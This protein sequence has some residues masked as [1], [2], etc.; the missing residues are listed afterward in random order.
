[1]TDGDL[2]EVASRPSTP[3]DRLSI[4]SEVDSI[5]SGSPGKMRDD[6]SPFTP[7]NKQSSDTIPTPSRTSGK[8]SSNSS[9]MPVIIDL[10]EFHVMIWIA[11]R[12]GKMSPPKMDVSVQDPAISI[13]E[14]IK[15][16][17]DRECV[18]G[19][20]NSV[21]TWLETQTPKRASTLYRKATQKS[22]VDVERSMQGMLKS[23]LD[24]P[25]VEI[26]K[27]DLIE[28]VKSIFSLFL[29]LTQ[30]G[31]MCSKLWGALH[32]AI[33]VS[34]VHEHVFF[35][36]RIGGSDDRRKYVAVATRRPNTRP[37]GCKSEHH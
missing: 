13:I 33:T 17:S 21:H 16:K 35:S 11:I 32:S 9:A 10:R 2:E 34:H 25:Q 5:R 22:L 3:D 19:Y 18:N 36:K 29:P 12:L 26:F 31:I 6:L 1:M 4:I 15:P 7:I 23:H 8:V 30:R 28:A 37:S 24:T 14:E 27:S 20:L